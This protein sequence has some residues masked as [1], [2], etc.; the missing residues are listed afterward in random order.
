MIKQLL[1]SC[2]CAEGVQSNGQLIR[3]EGATALHTLT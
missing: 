2:Q 1:P 3:S